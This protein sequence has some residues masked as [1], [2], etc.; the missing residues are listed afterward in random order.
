MVPE[1]P[2]HYGGE[3]RADR[4]E[5]CSWLLLSFLPGQ[6]RERKRMKSQRGIE[7]GIGRKDGR[8]TGGP[9]SQISCCPPPL[10]QTRKWGLI[11]VVMG[12]SMWMEIWYY[13]TVN[14]TKNSHHYQK[15]TQQDSQIARDS[16]AHLVWTLQ[17]G[18]LRYRRLSQTMPSRQNMG[19]GW[20]N[21][22]RKESRCART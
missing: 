16:K 21:C 14:Q 11:L 22:P 10:Q 18:V 20:L 9:V 1:P 17:Q 2:H 15:L 6:K 8:R 12:I 3:K 4:G 13:N 5:K 19:K 7:L